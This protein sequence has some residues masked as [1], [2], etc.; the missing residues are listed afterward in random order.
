MCEDADDDKRRAKRSREMLR[1]RDDWTLELVE[2][3]AFDTTLYW[4]VHDMP[5]FMAAI[6]NVKQDLP[7]LAQRAE[8][9]IEHLRNWDCRI[10]P[11]STAATLVTAWYEQLYG[12]EYPGESLRAEYVD[13]PIA[14]IEA[15]VSAADALERKFG[16]QQ[17]PW[18]EIHRVQRHA[19]MIDP[20]PLPFDDAAS[21]LPCLGGHGPMGIIFTQ[22][23]SPVLNIPFIET[24][25]KHYAMVGASYLAAYEFGER[26][27]GSTLVNFGENADPASPHFLDQA[28]LMATGKFKQELFHWDDVLA[29]AKRSYH[30]GQ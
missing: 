22:Y 3:A 21:S 26:F 6:Q 12:S 5:K 14:Q 1:A 4:A 8:P 25:K 11:E 23:Y 15:L 16:N 20:I 24:Q 19:R 17:V 18:A 30:P 10:T 28:T 2:Q 29:G 9:L 27:R 13:R 7:Q